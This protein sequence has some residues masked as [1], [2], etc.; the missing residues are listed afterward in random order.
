MTPFNQVLRL[1]L[2]RASGSERALALC[3][4]VLVFS[5]LAWAVLPI[6]AERQSVRTASGSPTARDASG[7]AAAESPQ[8][9]AAGAAQLGSVTT[10]AAGDRTGSNA[11]NSGGGC[12]TG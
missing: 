5:L 6:T 2:R 3:A 12:P 1:W 11:A 7:A 10:I 4:V 9:I 8:S